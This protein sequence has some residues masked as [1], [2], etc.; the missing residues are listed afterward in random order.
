MSGSPSFS[1]LRNIPGCGW[2]AL[3]V[4]LIHPQ[5]LGMFESFGSG[6]CAAVNTVVQLS[7]W[8]PDFN[9]LDIHPEVGLWGS[10][11][12][13]MSNFLRSCQIVSCSGCPVI[14][15]SHARGANFS[16]SSNIC[17]LPFFHVAHPVAT[18]LERTQ[19]PGWPGRA[20]AARSHLSQVPVPSWTILGPV[21]SRSPLPRS[22]PV[23]KGEAWQ[24]PRAS[25]GSCPSPRSGWDAATSVPAVP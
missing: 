22:V 2:T 13:S 6:Y 25:S 21:T 8:D 20:Q 15:T 10:Y 3:C 5:I 1:R 23:A 16:T 24:P 9:S 14:P 17:F 19:V 12:D 18:V 4:S 7:L 11:S